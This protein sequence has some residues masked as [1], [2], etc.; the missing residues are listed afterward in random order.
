[1]RWTS[2]VSPQPAAA[3]S[4]LPQLDIRYVMLL[5]ASQTRLQHIWEETTN[6]TLNGLREKSFR[7]WA[8]EREKCPESLYDYW[9][10]REKLTIEDGLILKADWIVVPSSLCREMLSIIHQ[11]Y[12]GREKC[13]L[14]ATT[15]IF[16]PGLT[17]DA[18]DLVKESEPCQR[19]QR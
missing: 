15:S 19:H 2:R 1:M 6:P 16:W 9:S 11:G 18:I 5:S 7:G 4:Q 13:L 10:F 3:N 12:L 14:R 17:K 8:D